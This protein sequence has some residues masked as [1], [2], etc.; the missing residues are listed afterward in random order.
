MVPEVQQAYWD[1]LDLGETLGEQEL[2]ARRGSRGT[3]LVTQLGLN[4]VTH[5]PSCNSNYPGLFISDSD[6]IVMHALLF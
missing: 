2:K 1:N 4:T 3:R 5:K 6:S